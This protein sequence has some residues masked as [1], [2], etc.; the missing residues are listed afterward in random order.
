MSWSSHHSR[1]EKLAIEA[2]LAVRACDAP[3]A[4]TLYREAAE[5][6]AAAFDAIEKGKDRTRGITAVSAV[7]LWYKGRDYSSAEQFAHRSLATGQLPPFAEVQLRN[8]LQSVWTAAAAA[9][10]G[11]KFVRGDVLVSVRGGEVIYGGAPLDLIVRKVD[12][13]QSLLFRTVEMLLERPFRK[14]GGPPTDVQAMFRPWLFQAPAGSYQFAV[15][16]QE[17]EQGRLFEDD[18]PKVDRVTSTFFRVLRAVTT[19]PEAE[20][21]AIVPDTQYRGAFLSLARNLAPVGKA[22]ERLEIREASAPEEP[23][24]SFVSDTRQELNAALRKMRPTVPLTD[25]EE[26][27]SIRGVLRAVHLDQDWLEIATTDVPPQHVHIDEAGDVL[28]DVIGPMVNRKVLVS[29]IRR[30]QKHIY[31]DIELDE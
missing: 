4:E 28:D 26:S 5:Q 7:S 8:L 13:I 19:D 21:A 27:A 17:P 25:A 9:K 24:V 30:G 10:A 3:R 29:A 23:F 22:F 1:S 18:R 20:L 31:R 15:R 12:G 16:M 6:E 14:R 2:E 11:V